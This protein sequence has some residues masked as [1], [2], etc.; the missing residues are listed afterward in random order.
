MPLD[1]PSWTVYIVSGRDGALYTGITTDLQRR[2]HEHNH[3]TRGARWCRGRR[4]VS[5]R[6][7]ETRESRGD[8]LRREAEIKRLTRE[9]KLALIGS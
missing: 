6:W 2:L 5:L 8:A 4:P 7:S 3:T 1:Q 9:E